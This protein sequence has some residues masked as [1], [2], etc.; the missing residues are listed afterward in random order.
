[1]FALESIEWILAELVVKF[2][3]D[4]RFA[5]D[6]VTPPLELCVSTLREIAWVLMKVVLLPELLRGIFNVCGLGSLWGAP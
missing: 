1:M 2:N 5:L 4:L 6:S 3:G